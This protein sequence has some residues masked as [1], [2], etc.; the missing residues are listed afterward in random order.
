MASRYEQVTG[1]QAAASGTAQRSKRAS[2]VGSTLHP[3]L[4]VAWHTPKYPAT[5]NTGQQR[6]R[7]RDIAH[8]LQFRMV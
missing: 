8:T 3:Q 2:P 4:P 5:V 7:I 1:G 6:N